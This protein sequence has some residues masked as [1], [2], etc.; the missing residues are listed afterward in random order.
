MKSAEVMNHI[1]LCSLSEKEMYFTVLGHVIKSERMD[2]LRVDAEM[3]QA[4]NAGAILAEVMPSLGLVSGQKGGGSGAA[5]DPNS[6]RGLVER[7]L[8]QHGPTTKLTLR[9]LLMEKKGWN[10]AK[11]EHNLIALY[12]FIKL[13]KRGRGDT[14][15]WGLAEEAA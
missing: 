12:Q 9:N 11:A 13:D 2:V 7:Y 10:R 5:K 8:Q 3:S 4:D 15:V 1:L 14:S 6:A